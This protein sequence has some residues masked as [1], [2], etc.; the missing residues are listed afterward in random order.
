MASFPQVHAY[1]PEVGMIDGVDGKI[2]TVRVLIMGGVHAHT[3]FDSTHISRANFLGRAAKAG[4]CF[5]GVF[6][7]GSLFL[8]APISEP[9]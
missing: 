2:D 9:T 5:F 6:S 1:I 8:S 7:L 4:D 3:S